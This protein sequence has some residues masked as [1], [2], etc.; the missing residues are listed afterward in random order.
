MCNFIA[1]AAQ[2]TQ[3]FLEAGAAKSEA[4]SQ[5][6]M[7]KA[8]AAVQ[9]YLSKDAK[10]RGA[11]EEGRYRDEGDKLKGAQDVAI[12]SQGAAAGTGTGERAIEDTVRNTELDALT[13]RSNAAREAYGYK[14]QAQDLLNNAKFVMKQGRI[15]SILA[16]HGGIANA[17]SSFM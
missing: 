11:I 12:A 16:V 10:R 17:A 5:A 6:S 2:M 13:I 4:K 1:A 7:Y 14:A 9:Q 3:G 15:K 8:N